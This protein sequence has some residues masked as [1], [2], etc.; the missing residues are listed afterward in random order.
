MRNSGMGNALNPL[1]FLCD[2]DVYRI[3]LLETS[4]VPYFVMADTDD[5]LRA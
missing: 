5:A 1:L 4:G 3:P 2:T